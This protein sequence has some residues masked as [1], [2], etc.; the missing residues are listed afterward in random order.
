MD[1]QRGW[2]LGFAHQV[3][4]VRQPEHYT[5]SATTITADVSHRVYMC[6]GGVPVHHKR[7]GDR[8][9][10]AIGGEQRGRQFVCFL[11]C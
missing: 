4:P 8:V 1:S 5:G 11:G 3:G 6:Q 9:V 2:K 10:A 7:R